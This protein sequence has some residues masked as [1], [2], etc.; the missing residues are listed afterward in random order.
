MSFQSLE[1]ILNYLKVIIIV[2]Y[3]EAGRQVNADFPVP[4]LVIILTLL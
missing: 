1:A 4:D 2:F 3:D